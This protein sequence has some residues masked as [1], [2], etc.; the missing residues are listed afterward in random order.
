MSEKH[1]KFIKFHERYYSRLPSNDMLLFKLSE[2]LE[3]DS[4]TVSHVTV[5]KEDIEK[6]YK[7]HTIPKDAPAECTKIIKKV[8]VRAIGIDQIAPELCNNNPNASFSHNTQVVIDEI[9][10]NY[11]LPNIT[12][13]FILQTVNP[14]ISM[15]LVGAIAKRF[16]SP[17]FVY[18]TLEYIYYL[19]KLIDL[20]YPD[21]E[22]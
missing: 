12:S 14:V 2:L 13:G 3:L 7:Q 10:N 16:S 1:P 18:T 15:L 20:L 11:K 4:I 8:C 5:P 19:Y 22:Y 21:F 9:L 6:M 17:L